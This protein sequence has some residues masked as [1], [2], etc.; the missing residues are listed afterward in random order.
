M[1]KIS[2]NSSQLKKFLELFGIF[3]DP[4]IGIDIGSSSVKVME[5]A[6]TEDKYF[7]KNFAIEK[8][9]VGDVVEKNIKNKEAVIQALNKALAKTKISSHLGCISI[10]NS[11][12]ISK[13]IQLENGLDEKEI[14]N[15]IE[16][17]SDRYIPY[18][19]EDVNLDF[20]I[21]GPSKI[22]NNLMDVILVATKKENIKIRTSILEAVGLHPK[23][24]DIESLS[25]ERVFNMLIANNL[26][27]GAKN[28]LIGL[29]DIGSTSTS[30]NVFHDLR[31]VYSKDQA[32]GGQQLLDEI[33]KRYGLTLQEAILARKHNDLPDDYNVDV[34]E[35]YRNKIAQQVVRA[36]QVFFSSAEYTKF[37]Y[38]CL[39]GGT[40]NL[41]GI[42][43]A[44][45]DLL[46]IKII[47]VNPLKHFTVADYIPTEILTEESLGLI[48]CC[49][50]ALR[51]FTRKL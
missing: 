49:G 20:E 9:N 28:K 25:V 27:D 34:L 18:D 47:I 8:L 26:P 46:K 29:F 12:A 51:N 41:P 48:N 42:D 50:L 19:L 15:E 31:L 21:L 38:I 3:T 39:T 36:C 32:F 7:I 6:H 11:V 43:E 22:G 5:I 37:D 33:Q 4:I 40:S 1:N 23:I 14:F 44:I 10:P 24:I 2:N 16:L 45:A 13:V 17:E 30:L 35:P